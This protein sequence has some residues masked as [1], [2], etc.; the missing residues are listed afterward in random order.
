MHDYETA[1][2]RKR[3]KIKTR[4]HDAATQIGFSPHSKQATAMQHL[5]IHRRLCNLMQ[6]LAMTVQIVLQ[7]VVLTGSRSQ[8]L[9]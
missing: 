7:A 9:L 6:L 8:F 1:R 2:T 5:R 4:I 3:V